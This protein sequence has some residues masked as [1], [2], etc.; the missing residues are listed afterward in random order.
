MPMGCSDDEYPWG[1]DTE[2]PLD[3]KYMYGRYYLIYNIFC[4]AI[5]FHISFLFQF[6]TLK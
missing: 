1:K 2:S 6:V 4:F 3:S 5:H